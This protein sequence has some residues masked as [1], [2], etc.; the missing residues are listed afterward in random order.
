MRREEMVLICS[1]LLYRVVRGL[2]GALLNAR[3]CGTI[4][5]VVMILVG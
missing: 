5:L 1:E 4:S 2:W 3:L